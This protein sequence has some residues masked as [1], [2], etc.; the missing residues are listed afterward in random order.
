MKDVKDN[1]GVLGLSS[2]N[3]FV[4]GGSPGIPVP[5]ILSSSLQVPKHIFHA[6]LHFLSS[7]TWWLSG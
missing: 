5:L 2:L 3:C 6:P 7:E 1:Q 4:T